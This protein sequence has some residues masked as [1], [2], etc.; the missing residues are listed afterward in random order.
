M[1]YSCLI[2]SHLWA[3]AKRPLERL[4][5]RHELAKQ[6]ANY[7]NSQSGTNVHEGADSAFSVQRQ[8][9]SAA[10]SCRPLQPV[11]IFMLALHT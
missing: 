5:G 7:V 10:H 11:M 8:S 6:G 4:V 3:T 9:S 2:D 1:G